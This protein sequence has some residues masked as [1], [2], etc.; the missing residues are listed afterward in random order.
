MTPNKPM[1]TQYYA[2]HGYTEGAEVLHIL[3]DKDG[4]KISAPA[5]LRMTPSGGLIWAQQECCYRGDRWNRKYLY[6]PQQMSWQHQAPMGFMPKLFMLVTKQYRDEAVAWAIEQMIK[7]L[8]TERSKAQGLVNR[9]DYEAKQWRE[10]R[11]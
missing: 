11:T 7:A 2:S 3:L 4:L 1:T 10:T 9:L 8:E 5:P 6:I